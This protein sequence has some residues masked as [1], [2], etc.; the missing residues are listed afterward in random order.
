VRGHLTVPWPAIG[1]DDAAGLHQ[2]NADEPRRPGTP[3]PRRT[4]AQTP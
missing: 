2:A 4:G 1:A 3:P